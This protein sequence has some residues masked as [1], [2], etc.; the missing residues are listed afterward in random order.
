MP[1][2]VIK[3]EIGDHSILPLAQKVA[4]ELT[5]KYGTQMYVPTPSDSAVF[6]QDD[7]GD[8]IAF[9]VWI[10]FLGGMWMGTVWTHPDHRQKGLFRQLYESLK[11]VGREKN[12]HEISAGVDGQNQASLTAHASLGM[13]VSTIYYS[14]KL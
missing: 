8:V 12:Y 6:L 4:A 2:L 13:K 1:L 3:P 11:D 7:C 14:E 9:I 5:Q 10:S